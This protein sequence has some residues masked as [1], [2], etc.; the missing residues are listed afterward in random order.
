MSRLTPLVCLLLMSLA[1]PARSQFV[2]EETCVG[3]MADLCMKA[4]WKEYVQFKAGERCPAPYQNVPQPQNQSQA[5]VVFQ[6][7]LTEENKASYCHQT[8]PRHAGLL[9][10][11]T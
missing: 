7:H 2:L 10:K 6:C 5:Y 11:K 8:F 9:A 1:D 4:P 3:T